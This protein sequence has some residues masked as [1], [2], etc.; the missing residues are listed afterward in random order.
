VS[1]TDEVSDYPEPDLIDL[2][3]DDLPVEVRAK[4]YRAM[5]PC[6]TLQ[7]SDE[8]LHILRAM[9]FLHILMVQ[10]PRDITTEREK[11]RQLLTGALGTLQTTVESSVVY[12]RQL[13][14]R[15]KQLP[16]N[17]ADGISPEVIATAINE[18]LRQQF[19]QSTIPETASRL[20]AVAMQLNDVTTAFGRTAT[21]LGNQ[22][23]GAAQ[24]ARRAIDDIERT[25]SRAMASARRG[26]EELVTTF[27]HEYRWSLYALS[28]LALL[29]GI[30]L[31]LSLYRWFEAQAHPVDRAPVVQTA[32]PPKPRVKH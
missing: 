25:S 12:Q 1:A 24:E 15:L 2:I 11:F 10:V 3:A 19:V 5:R 8:L 18:S 28:S 21:A 16:E 20:A 26:A 7:S 31:G 32:P 30:G 27:R 23:R 29:I 22:Y 13:D 6:R 4:Y 17:I 14:Q 9:M